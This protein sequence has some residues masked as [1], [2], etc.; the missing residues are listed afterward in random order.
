MATVLITDDCA[1]DREIYR[2]YLA[3]DPHQVYQILEASS[4][5]VGLA[6]FQSAQ[7]DVILL[8]FCL[9]DMTGL[10]FLDELKEQA[11]LP[12]PVIMLTGQGDERIAAQAIKR[13]AQDYL[14]KQQLE[15]N[16]LQL[17]VRTV[18]QQSHLQAE[19]SQGLEHALSSPVFPATI[20]PAMGSAATAS[21]LKLGSG[22]VNGAKENGGSGHSLLAET[23][24]SLEHEKQLSAFKSQLVA[25]I[26]HGYRSPLATILAAASTLKSHSSKLQEAQQQRFLELIENKARQMSQLVDDLLVLE[27]FESGKANFIPVPF[28]LLQ[29]FS[30]IL[31]THQD[32]VSDRHEF[33]LRVTGNTRGF[34]GDQKLLRH[35]VNSLLLAVT[36][37]APEGIPIEIHLTG[38]AA[39]IT[40]TIQYLAGTV[41][42]LDIPPMA[43]TPVSSVEHCDRGL[44]HHL[45]EFDLGFAVVKACV[46]LH[47]GDIEIQP[48]AAT[49][50]TVRLPKH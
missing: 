26:S 42:T 18:I 1:E 36:Q 14:V 13:G 9:P 8:D 23:L 12:L 21:H 27:T 5:E 19:L 50:V 6:L 2:E 45:S 20:S 35:I 31:T 7:C 46:Q 34:W 48:D 37:S 25:A 47:G 44:I 11:A 15:P 22:W 49:R 32:M 17:T 29:F 38:H 10:E 4:A 30:D 33:S 40:F 3:S 24:A 43:E 39:H 28:E 41:P 16:L